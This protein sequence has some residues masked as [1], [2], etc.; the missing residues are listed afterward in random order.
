MLLHCRNERH[1]D[2]A[3][4]YGGAFYRDDNWFAPVNLLHAFRQNDIAPF[5]T[6]TEGCNLVKAEISY[7]KRLPDAPLGAP[8]EF[9]V[10]VGNNL[11]NEDIRNPVSY[12]KDELLT[13]GASVRAF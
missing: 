9:T 13:P 7:A 10:G 6:A 8:R 1:H 2:R 12:S 4:W 3:L 11:L 5:E